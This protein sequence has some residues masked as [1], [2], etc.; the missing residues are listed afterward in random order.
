[1]H[2]G[3]YMSQPADYRLNVPYAGDPQL[4]AYRQNLLTELATAEGSLA[5]FEGRLR[6]AERRYS[7][8]RGRRTVGRLLCLI[9]IVGYVLPF[10]NLSFIP[11]YINDVSLTVLGGMFVIGLFFL[12]IAARQIQANDE[13]LDVCEKKIQA[14]RSYIAQTKAKL[15]MY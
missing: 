10:F 15:S 3:I 7:T 12:V 6:I 8:V 9:P 13:E 1:M 2:R 5:K 14:F 4:I 11:I